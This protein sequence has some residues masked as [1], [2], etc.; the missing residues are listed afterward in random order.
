MTTAWICSTESFEC[1]IQTIHVWQTLKSIIQHNYITLYLFLYWFKHGQWNDEMFDKYLKMP[2]LSLEFVLF[3]WSNNLKNKGI[4]VSI[5]WQS[6]LSNNTLCLKAEQNALVVFKYYLRA[7]TVLQI[8][9]KF[10]GHYFQI[11]WL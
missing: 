1:E 10:H 7:V 11:H 5:N 4:I 9:H 6:C 3:L 8:F 2:N